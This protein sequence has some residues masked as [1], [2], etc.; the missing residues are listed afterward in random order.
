[1]MWALGLE[2]FRPSVDRTFQAIVMLL[3][4]PVAAHAAAD[5]EVGRS[6]FNKACSGCH[7]LSPDENYY[8]PNLYCVIDRPV[9]SAP[10]ERY[11]EDFRAFG[12]TGLAWDSGTLST[13]LS[14]PV[15]F[16]AK[17]IERPAPAILMRVAIESETDRQKV[18][19]YLVS[20]C[21]D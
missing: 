15:A 11:T 16:V 8:A 10:F 17:K 3:F 6:L 21:P 13:F 12:A 2:A 5:V 1:M 20:R 7:S 18:I 4:V 9:A 19:E 14:N